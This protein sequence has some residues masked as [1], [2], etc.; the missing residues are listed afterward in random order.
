MPPFVVGVDGGTTKTIALAADAQGRILGAGRGGNS[1]ASGSEIERP[2]Q[3]VV[4]AVRQALAQAGLRGEEVALG[5]FGLAGADWPE[6]Y[7]RR[8]AF[9]A[10]SGVARRVIIKNDAL[11]GWRAS[12]RQPYGVVITAG[13][14]SNTAIITPAGQEWCYGYYVRYGGAGDVA[15]EAIY[16]VLRQEDGRGAPT[17]LTEMVLNRLNRP[18]P[19]ALLRAMVAGEL[20]REQVLSL[21]PLVFEAAAEGDEVAAEIVVKQGLALAEYA[22][23][24]IRRFGM[25]GLAFDVVLAGS[26]FKGR[27]PLLIDT[28]T[29]AIHCVAPGATIVR[30]RFEPSVGGVLLA[31]DALGIP[32][33]AEMYDHLARTTPGADFFSTL[34]DAMRTA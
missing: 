5:V 21:C 15:R 32:V 25:Q 6:D 4:A 28:I 20:Q 11:V 17:A 19:E 27:G 13:T 7:E 30:A 16:A 9:L 26:V 14:G 12:T 3:V 2:M 10:C 18:N 31:Y 34:D 29:Q 1:N 8:E 33:T 22:T 23:A 24:A